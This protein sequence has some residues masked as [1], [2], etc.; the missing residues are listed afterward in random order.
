LVECRSTIEAASSSIAISKCVFDSD[1]VSSMIAT[2]SAPSVATGLRPKTVREVT[3]VRVPSSHT[4]T[5]VATSVGAG[6][7]FSTIVSSGN[8]GAAGAGAG[9]AGASS[10]AGIA[11]AAGTSDT[12]AGGAVLGASATGS[13]A[14]SAGG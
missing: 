14:G 6:A 9:A 11:G 12:G 3:S 10:T 4:S 1:S 8:S 2:V 5:T 7:W 13:G